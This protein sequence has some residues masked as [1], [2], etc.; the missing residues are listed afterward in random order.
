MCTLRALQRNMCESFQL[1][2]TW[3]HAQTVNLHCR[4]KGIPGDEALAQR[5]TE[6]L[7]TKLDVYDVILSKQK[8]L[9]NY[10]EVM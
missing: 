4:S 10:R 8:Y 9:P 3:V 5:H 2:S 6:M 1:P 7:K